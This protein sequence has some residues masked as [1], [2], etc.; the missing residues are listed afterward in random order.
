ML[1]S[2][3]SCDESAGI[4]Q[5]V[6]L[7]MAV[8]RRKNRLGKDRG[9]RR[10]ITGGRRP[11]EMAR[12]A[13]SG[14]RRMDHREQIVEPL[15]QTVG[16]RLGGALVLET[17]A[18][19]NR[20]AVVLAVTAGAPETLGARVGVH[21]YVAAVGVHVALA[22]LHRAA[23]AADA[24]LCE[25]GDVQRAQGRRA[26]RVVEETGMA[27]LAAAL[28]GVLVRRVRV[29]PYDARDEC[30]AHEERA[31]IPEAHAI[32]LDPLDLSGHHQ[33]NLLRCASSAAVRLKTAN[34]TG[35]IDE[36]VNKKAPTT[37]CAQARPA[38]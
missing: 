27:G 16:R 6:Q 21:G 20:L 4:A 34:S 9:R 7:G 36:S 11:G 37:R 1:L 25:V 14:V 26:A 29:H 35:H 19:R 8:V 13:R 28:A 12:A 31:K 17:Q 38:T 15:P 32:H 3:F 2:Q 23:G 22:A 5:V 24:E 18:R 10:G 33:P 30:Q